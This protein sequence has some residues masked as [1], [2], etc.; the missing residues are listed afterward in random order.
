MNKSSTV[1][2]AVVAA[3]GLCAG[4]MWYT[5]WTRAT[6]LEEEVARWKAHDAQLEMDLSAAREKANALE[7]ESAQL[8]AA[9][10]LTEA[11]LE[12]A[13]SPTPQGNGGS[14]GRGGFLAKLFKDPSMRKMMAA[15]QAAALRGYYS[16]FVKEAHLTPDEAEK[17]FQLLEDRQAAL[18]DSSAAMLTGGKVDTSAMTAATNTANEALKDLLG[19]DGFAA[20]Q[21]FEKTLGDRIQVQQF[22]QQLG[23]VGSP[24]QDYQSQALI[25]IMSQEQANLPSLQAGNPQAMQQMVSGG[26]A[27][28]DQYTQEIDAMNQRVYNRAMSVLTPPQLSAFATFQKNMTTAQLAGLKMT[29]QMLKGDQ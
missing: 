5:E 10:A 11:R 7:S 18:M 2:L 16:D 14:N 23:A 29:Q 27:A 28:V 8:R 25:Q 21:D 13:A 6:G 9:H 20:Y 1:L 26:E 24:L 4:A 12:P 22:S 19:P 15:Q 17:F 3:C